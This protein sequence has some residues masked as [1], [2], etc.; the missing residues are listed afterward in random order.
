MSFFV[1]WLP[2]HFMNQPLSQPRQPG[3]LRRPSNAENSTITT[4]TVLPH[5][6]S[7]LHCK[8]LL[9]TLTNMVGCDANDFRQFH[10]AYSD[11]SKTFLGVSKSDARATLEQLSLNPESTI[12][13]CAVH[14]KDDFSSSTFPE[15]AD[16]ILFD[17][18]KTVYTMDGRTMGVFELVDAVS[19]GSDISTVKETRGSSTV[20]VRSA[21]GGHWVENTPASRAVRL[22]REM[23][24]N[25]LLT[26][27]DPRF[28]AR[29]H[30]SS[31]WRIARWAL[32]RGLDKFSHDVFEQIPGFV[33]L[34]QEKGLIP[35]KGGSTTDALSGP[36][37]DR[38]ASP[39]SYEEVMGG[40]PSSSVNEQRKCD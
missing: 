5:T 20:I 1:F 2:F 19:K 38:V 26:Q 9:Q 34:L 21:F 3:G 37:P 8:S 11:K 14:S 23:I 12:A 33:D 25:D 15:T 30:Q 39:P 7:P 31:A 24:E 13:T 27:R 18:G 32:D 10:V 28:R 17:G 4:E 36:A 35:P 22:R 16:L 40:G 6:P 29:T